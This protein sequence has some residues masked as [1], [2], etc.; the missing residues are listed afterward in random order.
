MLSCSWPGSRSEIASLTRRSASTSSGCPIA[1]KLPP[2]EHREAGHQP[3]QRLDDVLDP[4][5]GDAAAWTSRIVSSSDV[6]LGLGQAAG[7][8]VEQQQVA[9]EAPAPSPVRAVSYR[10]APA[11]RPEAAPGGQGRHAQNRFCFALGARERHVAAMYGGRQ[12][13]LEYA[14]MGEGLGIW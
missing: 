7:D 10:A 4:D 9:A 6:A 14:H 8:L 13:V 2:E 1:M 11:G 3:P 5:D 12:H